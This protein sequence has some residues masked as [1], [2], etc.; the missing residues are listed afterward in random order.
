MPIIQRPS[1]IVKCKPIRYRKARAGG[2]APAPRFLI[3]PGPLTGQPSHRAYSCS[4]TLPSSFL[5]SDT[6]VRSAC[7]RGSS[8]TVQACTER[9]NWGA[10]GAA[11]VVGQDRT[12]ALP[13]EAGLFFGYSTAWRVLKSWTSW[14]R[15]SWSRLAVWGRIGARIVFRLS[16]T[17]R[18]MYALVATAWWSSLIWHQGAL[19]SR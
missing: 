10:D 11:V 9:S 6:G 13:A 12:A 16:T 8:L 3:P 5:K 2:A 17:R 7:P 15:C 1:C 14:R 4:I 19:P 18:M